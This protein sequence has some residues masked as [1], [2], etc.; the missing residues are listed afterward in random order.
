MLITFYRQLVLLFSLLVSRGEEY[1]RSFCCEV[2]GIRPSHTITNSLSVDGML[3]WLARRAVRIKWKIMAV[4]I[5]HSPSFTVEKTIIP[6]QT[7]AASVV[8]DG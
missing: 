4:V 1:V 8:G 5:D 3:S 6:L 2:V 7:I